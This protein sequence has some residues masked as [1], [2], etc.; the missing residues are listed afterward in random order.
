MEALKHDLDVAGAVLGLT[1]L[2]SVSHMFGGAI[3]VVW[4]SDTCITY[5]KRSVSPRFA[6]AHVQVVPGPVWPGS[7]ARARPGRT[8]MFLV[9]DFMSCHFTWTCVRSMQWFSKQLTMV[10]A[11]SSH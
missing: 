8:T 10:V 9:R 3:Q 5:V 6:R 4:D 11:V 2:S 7:P 1:M